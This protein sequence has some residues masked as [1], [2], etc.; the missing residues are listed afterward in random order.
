MGSYKEVSIHPTP[1]EKANLKRE[2]WRSGGCDLSILGS[3]RSGGSS[4]FSML[5]YLH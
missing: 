1:K 2:C 5:Q 3:S 4:I